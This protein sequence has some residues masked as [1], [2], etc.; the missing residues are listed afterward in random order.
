[1]LTKAR[2]VV[3]YATENVLRADGHTVRCLSSWCRCSDY[4]IVGLIVLH[5]LER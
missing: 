2:Q 3:S 4:D 5:V 1:M